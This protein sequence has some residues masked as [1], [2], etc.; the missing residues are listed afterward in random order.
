MWRGGNLDADL[1]ELVPAHR[2][3]AHSNDPQQEATLEI[4]LIDIVLVE[5][6]GRSQQELAAVDQFEFP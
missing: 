5:N 2:E 4:E 1:H 6:K 3:P